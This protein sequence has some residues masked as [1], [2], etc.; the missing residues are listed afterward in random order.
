M[1]DR[2]I[3]K[4]AVAV[5]RDEASGWFYLDPAEADQHGNV[6]Q[7]IVKFER[8]RWWHFV[9]ARWTAR[10]LSKLLGVNGDP[11]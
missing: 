9:K 8:W 2:D 4:Y 1:N 3:P 6:K 5:F 11:R 10:R 7:Y